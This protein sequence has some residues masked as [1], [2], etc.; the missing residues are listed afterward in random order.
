MLQCCNHIV[1]I[2][3]QAGPLIIFKFSFL[4]F[5]T[6]SWRR[7]LW[8]RNQSSL[9]PPRKILTY[10]RLAN[11]ID[12]SL[13]ENFYDPDDFAVVEDPKNETVLT[14]LLGP[15]KNPKTKKI[16]WTNK[17]PQ[18]AKRLRPYGFLSQ[19]PKPST[20]LSLASR[21]NTMVDA[22]HVLF[23]DEIVQ[24]IASNS[25]AKIQH[26]KGNLP[27][28]YNRSDNNTFNTP[29]WSTRVIRIH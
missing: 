15:K 14:G 22:F 24:L 26:I 11:S 20:I 19:S 25:N 6:L 16:F 10:K 29:P 2:S 8:Y 3:R 28:Y 27:P 13:D 5:L 18:N 17:K 12:K 4:R 9:R 7:L 1:L 21:I 23:T